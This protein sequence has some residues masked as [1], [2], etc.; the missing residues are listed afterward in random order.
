MTKEELGELDQK[1]RKT[2]DNLNETLNAEKR[3]NAQG[4]EEIKQQLKKAIVGG[5]TLE[6]MG[7][8]WLTVGL[9]LSSL[10]AEMAPFLREVAVLFRN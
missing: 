9:L 5:I 4:F 6:T 3:N 10:S 8:I 7:V 2:T 1:L